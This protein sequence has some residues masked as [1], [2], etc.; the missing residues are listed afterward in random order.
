MQKARYAVRDTVY[1][2]N[3]RHHHPHSA[4]Q[5]SR[6]I[7]PVRGAGGGQHGAPGAAED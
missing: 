2:G 4:A 3:L 6:T 1:L 5:R 7:L